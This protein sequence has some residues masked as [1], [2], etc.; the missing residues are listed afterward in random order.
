MPREL[1]LADLLAFVFAA[2]SMRSPSLVVMMKAEAL[3]SVLTQ[4]PFG[5]PAT[6]PD[7]STIFSI[8]EESYGILEFGSVVVV[9]T[10]DSGSAFSLPAPFAGGTVVETGTV[11]L[12]LDT[13]PG[14]VVVVGV[15]AP[16]CGTPCAGDSAVVSMTSEREAPASD[17]FPAWSVTVTVTFQ[18]PSVNVGRLHEES[19]IVS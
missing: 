16:A 10:G 1:N 2:I 14:T 9:E 12:V 3:F 13:T 11:V 8:P 7:P 18:V 6:E 17:V 5:I 15:V 4:P 19:V